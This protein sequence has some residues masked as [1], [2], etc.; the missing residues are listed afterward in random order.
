MQLLIK[1]YLQAT[2]KLLTDLDTYRQPVLTFA[3]GDNA[4]DDLTPKRVDD[5]NLLDEETPN[6]EEDY[7]DFENMQTETVRFADV[8]KPRKTTFGHKAYN[9]S[10]QVLG[11]SSIANEGIYLDKSQFLKANTDY[12]SC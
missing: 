2:C 12:C 4:M 5:V 1:F 9:G 3:G 8:Q 7:F 11:S 6:D 10:F